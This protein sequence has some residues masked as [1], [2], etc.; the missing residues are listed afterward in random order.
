MK[1]I[2]LILLLSISSMLAG[3][4]DDIEIVELNLYNCFLR[5]YEGQVIWTATLVSPPSTDSFDKF[6]NYLTDKCPYEARELLNISK[7]YKNPSNM[8]GYLMLNAVAN[9]R[10]T[11]IQGLKKN[12]QD[13]REMAKSLKYKSR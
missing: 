2:V 9:M 7:K 5:E 8:L 11:L 6:H 13:E 12:I 1:K 3:E 4:K 10:E